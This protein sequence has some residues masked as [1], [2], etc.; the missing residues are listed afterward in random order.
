MSQMDQTE[1]YKVETS[2]TWLPSPLFESQLNRRS[3]K[4]S[5]QLTSVVVL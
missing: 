3:A 2:Y 1:W 4:L 5:M